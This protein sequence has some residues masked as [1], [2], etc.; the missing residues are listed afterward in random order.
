[1]NSQLNKPPNNPPKNTDKQTQPQTI[2][3]NQVIF[4]IIFFSIF[5]IGFPIGIL[6]I[7]FSSELDG[8]ITDSVKIAVIVNMALTIVLFISSC[9]LAYYKKIN[10]IFKILC[11]CKVLFSI[12]TIFAIVKHREFTYDTFFWLYITTFVI[13][14]PFTGIISIAN[15]DK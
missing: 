8:K 10:R 6:I 7:L 12:G 9:V 13:S 1:M 14:L 4:I 3:T 5:L 2:F 15:L 11:F